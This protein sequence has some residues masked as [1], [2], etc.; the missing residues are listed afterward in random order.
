MERLQFVGLNELEV[1]DANAVLNVT[2]KHMEKIDRILSDARLKL[3]LKQYNTDG[4]SKFSVDAHFSTPSNTLSV[5]GD[6]W[7]VPEVVAEVLTKAA[8]VL[9]KRTV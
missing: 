3:V 2:S 8:T 9:E 6:G 1:E 7:N 5:D 4:R